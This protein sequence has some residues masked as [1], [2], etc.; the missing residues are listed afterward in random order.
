[1]W[2]WLLVIHTHFL[3]AFGLEAINILLACDVI[4]Y[5]F[6]AHPPVSCRPLPQEMIKYAREDTHYLLYIYDRMSNELIR[7]SNERGSLLLTV[8]DNSRGICCRGY[9]RPLVS[10]ESYLKLYYKHKRQFN[11]QQVCVRV[12]RER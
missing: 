12:W 9:T 3:G 2:V 4:V 6:M 8:L 11:A 5:V 7:R 1:M 10:K